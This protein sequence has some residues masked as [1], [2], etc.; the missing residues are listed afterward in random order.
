MNNRATNPK[1]GW[2]C[3]VCGRVNSPNTTT[4]PCYY[5]QHRPAEPYIQPSTPLQ[6][7]GIN[8]Y[9]TVI[10]PFVEPTPTTQGPFNRDT[11]NPDTQWTCIGTKK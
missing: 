5:E 7:P 1:L 2:M 8:P 10:G 6:Q 4:C 9:P 11:T 3:P